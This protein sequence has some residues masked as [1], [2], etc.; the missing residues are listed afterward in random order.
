MITTSGEPDRKKLRNTKRCDSETSK[1]ISNHQLA[2]MVE[3]TMKGKH[4]FCFAH[5]KVQV[6]NLENISWSLD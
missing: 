3:H 6:Q 2:R 5:S 4:K 1:Q